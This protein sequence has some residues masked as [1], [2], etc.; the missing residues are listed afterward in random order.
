M[1]FG[2]CAEFDTIAVNPFWVNDAEVTIRGSFNNPFTH[3]TALNLVATGRVDVDSMVTDR[4]PL[5][6]LGDAMVPGN[7][8]GSMKVTIMPGIQS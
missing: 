7:F 2:C 8:P 6:R 3:A 4:I 5:E 1:W